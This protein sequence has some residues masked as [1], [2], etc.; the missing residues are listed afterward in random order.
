MYQAREL[1]KD[2]EA[3]N[4]GR[5]RR[6]RQGRETAEANRLQPGGRARPDGSSAAPSPAHRPFH[7]EFIT[8]DGLRPGET[9]AFWRDVCLKRSEP[10]G[11]GGVHFAS[12]YRC[13]AAPEGEFKDFRMTPAGLA[14]TPRLCR[15]DGIDNIVLTLTLSGEGSGWFGDP[16]QATRLG[17]GLV[18]IRD[19]ARPYLLQWTAAE[20]R[21]LNLDLPRT[22]LDRRTLERVLAAAGT[23][24]PNQNLVPLLAAQMRSL[25][26]LAPGLDP[27]ARAAGLRSLLD[28][29]TTVLS[30][31]FDRMAAESEVCEDGMLIAAQALIRRSFASPDLAPEDIARKIGCSRAHLYRLFARHGLT[32]AGYLREVRL[33]RARAALMAAGPRESVG[34]IAFRS[35]FDNPVH[36]TQLFRSRFGIRPGELR[37]RE[38][39]PPTG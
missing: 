24:M 31:E 7:H 34:D 18:R 5:D 28:L 23:L 30:L 2:V 26:E 27:A 19:R 9:F 3:S 15:H 6:M 35:G 4:P 36:F 22:A 1:P 37:R 13:L 32:V 17:G 25:A 16:D 39:I 33:E 10:A 14:R 12:S 38:R 21:V 20:N 11:S 29:A 8:T